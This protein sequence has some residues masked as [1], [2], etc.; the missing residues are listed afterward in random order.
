MIKRTQFFFIL[1]LATLFLASSIHAEGFIKKEVYSYKDA[2]GNVVFT[3]RKP[4]K[5]KTFEIQTIEAANSTAT[6]EQKELSP[7]R[8]TINVYK[9]TTQTVRIIVDKESSAKKSYKKKTSLRRCKKYKK[10]FTHYSDKLKAG[11]KNSEYKK[12]ASNREKYKNLLFDNCPTKTF[13]D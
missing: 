6:T 1:S 2:Q 5:E 9:D 8:N 12:L 3:D 4:N 7:Y 11:Y 10:K 13:N